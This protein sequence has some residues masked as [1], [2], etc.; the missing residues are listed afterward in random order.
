MGHSQTELIES[1]GPPQQVIE[2]GDKTILV[3]IKSYVYRN[4]GTSM[5]NTVGHRTTTT[6]ELPGQSGTSSTKKMFWVDDSGTIVGWS[7]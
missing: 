6:T 5:P 4:P 1:W 2:D 7:R 3:Y